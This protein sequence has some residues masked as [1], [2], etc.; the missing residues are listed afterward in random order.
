MS[1]VSTFVWGPLLWR[2]LHTISFADPDHLRR[3]AD[4]VIAFLTSL[5]HIL[6]CSYCRDS[7]T[8]Y[9]DQLPALSTTIQNSGL[10]RWMYDLHNL[11]NAKLGILNPPSFDLVEK[12]YMVRPVQWSPMDVWDLLALLGFNFTDSKRE[13]YATFW[14]HLPGVL[15]LG[16][17]VDVA[18][19]DL[20]SRAPCPREL[21]TFIAVALLLESTHSLVPFDAASVHT[22]VNK[23]KRAVSTG[24]HGS[25]CT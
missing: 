18:V 4:A 6:P 21:T 2:I 14:T 19:A 20:L 16:D 13:A 12:R 22:R 17:G 23:Y 1:G 25:G 9:M 5:K 24:C 15:R 10:S 8:T 3:H 7:Y 11:V